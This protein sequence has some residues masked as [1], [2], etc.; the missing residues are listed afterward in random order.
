MW[1]LVEWIDERN[2]FPTYGIVNV[3]TPAYDESEMNP[4]K[5]IVI[6]VKH[7]NPRRAQI[8]RISGK[9]VLKTLR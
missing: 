7:E 5:Q 9:F 1:F 4:G 2:V 8:L 6:Q 3:D